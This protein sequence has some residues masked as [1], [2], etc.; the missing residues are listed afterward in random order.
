MPL[1]PFTS[2]RWRWLAN[3]AQSVA[4]FVKVNDTWLQVIGVLSDI[5]TVSM[6]SAYVNS[7]AIAAIAAIPGLD[8]AKLLVF[9]GW[10]SASRGAGTTMQLVGELLGITN[11]FQ[12]VDKLTIG[13]DGA[14]ESVVAGAESFAENAKVCGPND[15]TLGGLDGVAD[16]TGRIYVLDFVA[17]NVRVME[18]KS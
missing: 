8:R 9:G 11:Q 6:S 18:A 2:P 3:W 15:C 12:G 17:N 13:A 5:T 1:P 7:Q 14:F 10:E 16:A 4:K